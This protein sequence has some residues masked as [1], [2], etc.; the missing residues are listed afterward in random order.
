[1]NLTKSVMLAMLGLMASGCANF[2]SIHR[3]LKVDEGKGALIDIKQRA[4]IVSNRNGE[5]IVCAEPSPDSL[6]AYA[7]ELS[8]EGGVPE[9]VTASLA[10][11]FQEGSSFVG[12]R[13][14]SIQLLRDSLYRLCEGYMNGA[15]D[16]AQYDI[17]M[18][19]YQKYMVA[20]L[21]IEQLTGALRSPAVAITTQGSASIARSIS[22]VR[23]EIEK[24]DAKISKLEEGKKVA[25]IS[26]VEKASL[27]N[28][29]KTLAEDKQAMEG[30]VKAMQRN[31]AEGSANVVVSTDGQPVQRNEQ[32]I[33]EV[34]ESVKNIVMD[35]INTD[36][37]G[38]LCFA[39]LKEAESSDE[40]TFSKSSKK[41]KSDLVDSCKKFIENINESNRAKID[42]AKKSIENYEKLT[43]EQKAN[44][45]E[46][47]EKTG[48]V[49]KVF[50]APPPNN[51]NEQQK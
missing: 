6:S 35:I 12:L 2:N 36:D 5:T 44:L 32:L 20:L 8:G 26:D 18:R 27:D 10:A 23:N 19:R 30:S 17:L 50:T 37:T 39:Y 14:Q 41:E 9:E 42:Y 43:A 25:G 16:S 46:L 31:L 45:E 34:S 1:M 49:M 47:L 21:A 29:I 38:Q 51:R 33:Q 28:K 15:L 7:A 4:L 22:E 24:I 13:T 3:D 40:E 48:S 11:A